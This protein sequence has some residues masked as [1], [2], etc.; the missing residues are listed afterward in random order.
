[1]KIYNKSN[2]GWGLFLTAIGLAM[3]AT[4]IWTGFDVK[5]TVLMVACLAFG[6]TFLGRSFSPAMSREDKLA[7]LDERNRLIKLRARS[8]ALT[9]TQWLCLALLI[10]SRLAVG[11]F[12]KEICAA[13]TI[14]F[15]LLY[16]I[17]FVTELIALA[18][19]ERK[20]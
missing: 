1:M 8:A 20:L 18:Y 15:G 4:S 16:V 10:L 5:G 17:L 13:L 19:F 6:V 11:L 2:F 12:G 3:L 7:E 9:W 14:A